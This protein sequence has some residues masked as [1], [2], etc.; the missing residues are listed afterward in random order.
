MPKLQLKL[1]TP[2]RTVIAEEVGSLTCPT[3][4][5]QITILPGHAPLVANLISGELVAKNE[6]D[7]R[8]IHVAGGVIEVR[9]NGEIVVLADAAEHYYEID[10]ARAEQATREAKKLL[11]E[12]H[13]ADEEYATTTWLLQKNLSRIKIARKHAHRRTRSITGEG[14][15]RE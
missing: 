12:Q 8:F 10:L 13:L 6:G 15:F 3:Q 14:V 1:I 9:K 4:E 7:D 5:G 11:E 2:E